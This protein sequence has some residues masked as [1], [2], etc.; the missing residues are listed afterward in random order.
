[1][2]KKLIH[3]DFRARDS[4]NN[5]HYFSLFD[6]LGEDVDTDYFYIRQTEYWIL[7]KTVEAYTGL[8]D[9]TGKKIYEGDIITDSTNDV[10]WAVYWDEEGSGWGSSPKYPEYRLYKSLEKCFRVVGNLTDNK[11]LR[12]QIEK[13]S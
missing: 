2:K 8:V 4:L 12:I 6:V 13:Q 5:I 3:T 1:M 9:K 7:K 10:L 11:L